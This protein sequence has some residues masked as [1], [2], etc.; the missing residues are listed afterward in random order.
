MT[1]T[2]E[3]AP[4]VVAPKGARLFN[5]PPPNGDAALEARQAWTRTFGAPP[6]SDLCPDILLLAVAWRAEAMVHG[7]LS[8]ELEARLMILAGR[9]PHQLTL[10]AL[11]STRIPAKWDDQ[12]QMIAAAFS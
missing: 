6:P 1:M 11:G 3:P 10:Q 8:D 2:A 5:K 12:R 4:L 7:G 9:Q